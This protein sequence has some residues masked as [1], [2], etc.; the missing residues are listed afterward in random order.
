ME[1]LE[2]SNIDKTLLLKVNDNNQKRAQD[3]IL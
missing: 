1:N 3:L 2:I